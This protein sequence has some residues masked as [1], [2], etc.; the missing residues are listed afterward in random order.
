MHKYITARVVRTMKTTRPRTL[1]ELLDLALDAI[2][3]PEFLEVFLDPDQHYLFKT[4][5]MDIT[6]ARDFLTGAD[7]RPDCGLFILPAT[8]SPVQILARIAGFLFS[9]S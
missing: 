8:S 6:K 2:G 7:T 3:A 1:I 9:A 4:T 5:R